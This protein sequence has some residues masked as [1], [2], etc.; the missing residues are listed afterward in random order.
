MTEE[1][2]AALNEKLQNPVTYKSF[3]PTIL[4]D[5]IHEAFSEDDWTFI[6]VGDKEA[7]PILKTAMPCARFVELNT[8]CETW[9]IPTNIFKNTECIL[10][11]SVV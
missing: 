5:G 3:R 6:R 7:G 4:L 10:L 9:L 1:S 11:I 2:I 8:N